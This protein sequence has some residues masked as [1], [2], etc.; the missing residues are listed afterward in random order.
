MP[1]SVLLRGG[2]VIHHPAPGQV[3][4]QLADVLLAD[5]RVAAVGPGLSAPA[6]AEVH[7]CKGLLVVPGLVDIHVHFREPGEEYKEDLGSGSR[8]AL[9]G[10]FSTVC[11]MPNTKPTNDNR[12]V[13]ELIVRRA[14][15]MDGVRIRPIGALTKGLAGQEL[16]DMADMQDAGAV[17]VSDD[18]QCVMNAGLMRRAM[19][20]ARTFGLPVVQ[21]CEDHDLSGRNPMNEGPVATSLG[22]RGQPWVAE[23]VIV[24]RDLQLLELVG[25]RY[26]VAHISTRRS[27]ELVREGKRRGL[28]VTAEV[29]PHHLSL[30]DSACALYDTACKCAPPLRGKDDV[31]AVREGL[32][33]GTIDAVATDHA[34]HS[35]VEKDVEF[36]LAAFGMTGLETSLSLVLELVSAGVLSLPDAI[37]RMTAGPARALGLS[38]GTLAVGAPGDVAVLDPALRWTVDPARMLSKSKNTPFSGR[39]LTGRAVATYVG[40]VCKHRLNSNA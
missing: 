33:D 10:G 31:A 30:D 34:P 29:T 36:D 35:V 9:A 24:A 27:V 19:E 13:T 14:R 32:A 39:A 18:G 15:E 20:Y 12:T 17:A 4:D 1:A 7:D 5:G 23:S 11:A 16:A 26:H 3:F 22:L 2:R 21:H 40:G 28:A 37:C 6:G 8:S 38:A 25:G